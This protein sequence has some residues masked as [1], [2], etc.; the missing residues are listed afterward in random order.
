MIYDCY[1]TMIFPYYIRQHSAISIKH[2]RLSCARIQN[3]E[4]NNLL[5]LADNLFLSVRNAEANIFH[6]LEI[7]FSFG[8]II[9]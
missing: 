6:S 4:H 2:F 5:R 1:N 3:H 7:N 9:S 8:A